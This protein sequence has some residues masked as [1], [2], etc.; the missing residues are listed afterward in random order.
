MSVICPNWFVCRRYRAPD[1]A[2]VM[3][4]TVYGYCTH[5]DPHERDG[6]CQISC[7]MADHLQIMNP[8]CVE[9]PEGET[10]EEGRTE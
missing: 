2:M 9:I 10:N 1:F 8:N 4:G 5:G 6:S 7:S 3:D